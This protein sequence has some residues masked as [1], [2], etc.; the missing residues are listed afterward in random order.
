M[1]TSSRTEKSKYEYVVVHVDSE[2]SVEYTAVDDI[3]LM[4]NSTLILTHPEG[5]RT[6]F[7]DY[8]Y[9]EYKQRNLN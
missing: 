8:Q 5:A 3:E 7:K 1:F 9:A 6:I 2:R 4:G